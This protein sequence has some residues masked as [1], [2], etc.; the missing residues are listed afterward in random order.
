M[1]KDQFLEFEDDQQLKKLFQQLPKYKC[2]SNVTKAVAEKTYLKKSSKSAGFLS[3]LGDFLFGQPPVKWAGA[4]IAV[5]MILLI[6]IRIDT[7]SDPVKV[8]QSEYSQEELKKVE[9]QARLS[10]AYVGQVMNKSKNNTIREV[11]LKQLP[12]TIRES[13]NN[14]LP[15]LKGGTE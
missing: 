6:L 4:A 13:V 10:L 1:K 2:P 15:I 3:R 14:A 8:V 11:V 9:A 12:E 5:G 7:L